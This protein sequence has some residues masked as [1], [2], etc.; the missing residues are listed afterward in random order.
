[1]EQKGQSLPKVG[2]TFCTKM[3][4]QIL[5]VQVFP[6]ERGIKGGEV[7]NPL[8]YQLWATLTTECYLFPVSISQTVGKVHYALGVFAVS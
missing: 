3:E 7:A 8:F 6:K 5:F 4:I 2:L 1:M